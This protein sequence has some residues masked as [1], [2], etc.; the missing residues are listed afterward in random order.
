MFNFYLF[1]SADF[2]IWFGVVYVLYLALGHKWQ[3]RL[4]LVASYLFY[5][6]WDWRFLSLLLISTIVDYCAGL[7]ISG[8]K[9]QKVRKAALLI[10]V[11][12]NLGILA[13]FKYFNFF[14]D[15]LRE[16]LGVIGWEMS[17]FMINVILPVGIS[18]Y[19]FQT[20]SYTIDIYRKKFVPTRNIV[21]FALFVSFFPQLVA[22]PI[23]R[24]KRLLPQ[25]QR[26]RKITNEKVSRGVY[27]I[28]WGLF[29]KVV[30]ADSLAT[31]IDPVFSAPGPYSGIVVLMAVYAFA[32][33]IYADFSGYSDM[34][35]GLAYLLGFRLMVNFR[36][37]YAAANPREFWQRW[38]ISLS[39][40]LRDYL[41]IPLGGNRRGKV[42]T[43]INLMVTM[44]L[45]GLWHGAAWTF[46]IWGAYHGVWLVLHKLYRN[47]TKGIR[48][49]SGYWG[50]IWRGLAIFMTWHGVCVG[51]LFFRAESLGQAM[52]MMRAVPLS[53]VATVNIMPIVGTGVFIVALVAMVQA[54]QLSSGQLLFVLRLKGLGRAMFWLMVVF[55]T[56]YVSVFT[57]SVG[58]QPFI[59]FQF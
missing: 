31:L 19:T 4:L 22:G 52:A 18:F 15:S 43:L 10:S 41:Y 25:I 37:P 39:T 6:S 29:K 26:R 24:A 57:K 56:I 51:W 12:T 8:A 40:W 27:L 34:A 54:M 53:F 35:R 33:Q 32:W 38:H 3:N 5:A 45:G 59:Y 28:V 14:A 50:I 48:G 30:V 23:E 58:N 21:D 47:L 17:P 46:V 11:G 20:M 36:I 1:S 2:F 13:G 7:T 55:V 42:R 44:L 49:W 16:L 9:T